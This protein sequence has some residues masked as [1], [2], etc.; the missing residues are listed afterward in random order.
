MATDVPRARLAKAATRV[1]GGHTITSAPWS[2]RAAAVILSNSAAELAS[3]FIF[4]FPATSGRR[5]INLSLLSAQR[6]SKRFGRGKSL[7]CGL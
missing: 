2:S 3:P 6:I 5:A 4:Q 1:A 7:V